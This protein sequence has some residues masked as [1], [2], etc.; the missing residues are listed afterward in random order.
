MAVKIENDKGFLV[1]KT[2]S[3]SEGLKLGGI[4]ICDSCNSPSFKGYYIAFLNSWY[5]EE[6]YNDWYTS[7]KRYNEDIAIEKRNFNLY[8]KILGL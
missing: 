3:T 6:C 1:I 8:S 5:D 7:A 2:E 4:C